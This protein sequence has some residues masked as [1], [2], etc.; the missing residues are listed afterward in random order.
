MGSKNDP[1]LGMAGKDGNKSTDNFMKLVSSVE[2]AI[3]RRVAIG[4]KIS[5][6]KLHQEMLQRFD[7]AKAIDYALIS[8]IRRDE[9]DHQEGRK[10]LARKRWEYAQWKILLID[11]VYI[12]TLF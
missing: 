10:I 4:T 2:E 1:I 7:N 11:S 6:P 8:M 12:I 3:K 9:F 5:Y